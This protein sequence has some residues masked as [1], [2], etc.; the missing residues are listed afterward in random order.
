MNERFVLVNV[1]PRARNFSAFQRRHQRGLIH[2]RPPRCIDQKGRRLHPLKFWRIKQSP[3]LRQQRHVHADKVRFRQQRIHIPKLCLQ[4]FLH[5]FRGAHR[6][7]VNHLHLKTARAP[8]HRPSPPVDPDPNFSNCPNALE[9]HLRSA[10]APQPSSASRQNPPS[11]HPAR[12]ACLSPPRLVSC[13]PPR[14]CC[15]IPP[16]RSTRCAASA[17]PSTIPR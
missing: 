2:H 14:R 5:A 13:T 8:R 6:I 12:L 10:V 15:Q 9:L 7:R 16:L 11:F 17:P 4:L 3:R 1:Q